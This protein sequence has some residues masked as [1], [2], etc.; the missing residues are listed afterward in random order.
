MVKST[1]ASLI[2]RRWGDA[3]RKSTWKWRYVDNL[4]PSLAY[5]LRGH[6][7]TGEAARVLAELNRKG[8]AITSARALLGPNSCYEELKAAVD[9]REH[10][11][12]SQITAARLTANYVDGWKTYI[13]SLLAERT[14]LDSNDIFVR[15][16]LQKPVLAIANAYFGMYTQLRYYDV[17]HTFATGVPARDSQLWHR[18]PEDRY[19]LKV[20]VYLSDAAIVARSN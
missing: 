14:C 20:F 9:R 19:I 1:I 8:V 4:V 11:L 6:S 2:P 7:L 10:D 13:F 17:W 18:D 16:P 5:R 3:Y 15:F 12:D